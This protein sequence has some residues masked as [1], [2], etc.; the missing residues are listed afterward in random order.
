MSHLISATLTQE[1]YDI[2]KEWSVHRKASA[3]ISRA[4]ADSRAREA[5]MDAIIIQKNI[6]R[7]RWEY[8]ERDLENLMAA[9]KSAEEILHKYA[10]QF[11]HTEMM[12]E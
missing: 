7:S 10:K 3:N 11:D 5:R 6:L 12:K 2:Y 4:I 9:G 8:L 1:A